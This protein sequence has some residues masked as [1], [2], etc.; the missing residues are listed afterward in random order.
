MTNSGY[1]GLTL[2]TTPINLK[3]SSLKRDSLALLAIYDAMD[4]VNWT[5]TILGWRRDTTTPVKDWT[6][7]VD[8]GNRISRINLPA[9]GLKNEVPEEIRDLTKREVIDFSENEITGLP[10]LTSMSRLASVNV[11]GNKLEFDDFGKIL[12]SSMQ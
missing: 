6:G 2:E 1:P 7:I 11:S 10:D 8:L 12:I 5:G 3:V 4:G 9:R